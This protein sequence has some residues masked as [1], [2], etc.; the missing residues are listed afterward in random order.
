V[1]LVDNVLWGGRVL[2]PE[3]VDGRAIAAFNDQV[4]RDERVDLALLP[5][6][7]GLTLAH[8]R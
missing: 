5:I 4:R 6:A 1:I 3:D 8:R 7:D 2:A